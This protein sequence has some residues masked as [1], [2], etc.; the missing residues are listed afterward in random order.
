MPSGSSPST[1]L[2]G[3]A[4]RPVIPCGSCMGTGRILSAAVAARVLFY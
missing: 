2:P 3:S 4:G 1:W